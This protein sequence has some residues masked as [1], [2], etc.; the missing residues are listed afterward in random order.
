MLREP[1][2]ERKILNDIKTPPFVLSTRRRTP[3]EFFSSL[4][5]NAAARPNARVRVIE[6]SRSNWRPFDDSISLKGFNQAV[7]DQPHAH[8]RDEKTDDPGRSV[9]ALGAD[10]AENCLGVG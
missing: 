2:H 4:L 10:A 1:Q 5:A 7:K 9:Y 3:T 8:G 6:D